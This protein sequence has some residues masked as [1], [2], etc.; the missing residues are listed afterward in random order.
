MPNRTMP[1]LLGVLI[2]LM[3]LLAGNAMLHAQQA[4]HEWGF[5]LQQYPTGSI[6]SLRSNWPAGQQ[7]EAEFRLGANIIYHGDAGVHQN[8]EGLGFGVSLGGRYWL[9]AE[10]TG[11]Q[12]GARCDFWR[13]SLDW[14]DEPT[15]NMRISGETNVLVVQPTAFLA[16][17]TRLGGNWRIVPNIALGAEINTW[18]Q[19]EDVGQG[20]I[21]LI[22]LQ[23]V[24][25]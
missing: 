16:Y 1:F 15:P 24:R 25:R 23:L 8:E 13:N 11:W 9:K 6:L 19:G 17:D 20:A 14:R 2:G 5:D 21:L 3:T 7:L 22:G 4:F 12:L 10:K 18:Q